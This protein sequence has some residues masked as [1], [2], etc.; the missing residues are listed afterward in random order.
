MPQ[1]VFG[2]ALAAEAGS[3]V[4][5]KAP[6]ALARRWRRFMASWVLRPSGGDEE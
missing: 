6:A 3:H 2:L 4:E 5:A 1:T